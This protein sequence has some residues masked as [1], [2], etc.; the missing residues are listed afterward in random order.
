MTLKH[1]LHL[2]YNGVM[3][4]LEQFFLNNSQEFLAIYFSIV[5]QISVSISSPEKE[6]SS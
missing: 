1:K 2:L 4:T 6:S 5:L 3:F